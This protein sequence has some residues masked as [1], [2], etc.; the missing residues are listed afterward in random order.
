MRRRYYGPE[1]PSHAACC[2]AEDQYYDFTSWDT[3]LIQHP[4]NQACLVVRL[5]KDELQ[6]CSL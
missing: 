2:Q 3:H 6:W 4:I 1:S 5:P